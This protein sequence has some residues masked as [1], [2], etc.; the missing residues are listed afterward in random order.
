MVPTRLIIDLRGNH[1]NLPTFLLAANEP[2]KGVRQWIMRHDMQTHHFSNAPEFL[3]DVYRG[4]PIA[5][6]HRYGRWHVYLDY[7]LQHDVMFDRAENAIAWLTK[8]ID[9]S[10]TLN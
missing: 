8:R 4:R 2:A 5:I 7:K 3:S 10:V 9:Q 1:R 6:L